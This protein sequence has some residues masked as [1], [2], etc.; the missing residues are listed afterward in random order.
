MAP[1]L[2]CG[3]Y[4]PAADVFSLG[5]SILELACNIEVPNGGEGWQQL[6]QGCLPTEFTKGLSPEFQTVLEMMLAPEPSQRPTVSELL[7][8]P[9][10]KKRRWKRHV[11]LL[12]TETVLALTSFCQMALCFGWRVLFSLPWSFVGHWKKSPPRTPPKESWDKDLT[13]PPSAMMAESGT[14][15]E[16]SVFFTDPVDPDLSPTLSHRL[17]LSCKSTSTPL[18]GSPPL[19][20]QSPAHTR[21]RSVL[22]E[23]PPANLPLTPSSINSFDSCHDLTP[24][25]SPIHTSRL[26]RQSSAKSTGRSSRNW[27]RA[28]ELLPRPNFEPKNLLSL[29]DETTLD[30][31]P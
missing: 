9:C 18:P 10:V 11:Y 24:H 4:G 17:I 25:G 14:P 7:S 16:E 23:W 26:S 2:L 22:R 5:V 30:G 19:Y 12:I 13:L 31:Q 6:R 15:E 29:F 3:V 21:N 8:L 1:E 28:D 20:T 27:V